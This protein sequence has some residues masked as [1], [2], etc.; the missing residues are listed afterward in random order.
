MGS[1]DF[2]LEVLVL[3]ALF[4][5]L[6]LLALVLDGDFIFGLSAEFVFGFEATPG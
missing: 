4:G 5:C 6:F 1:A 2:L 3:V